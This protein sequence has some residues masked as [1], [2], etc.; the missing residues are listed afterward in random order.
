MGIKP[1]R[2]L[3]F[4][5][6]LMGGTI[7]AGLAV[8]FAPLGLPHSVVK[9]GGSMLW[10]LMIYWVVS[11]LLRRW[12]VILAAIIAGAAATV[13][14]F[15]KLYQAPALNAF[16]L[17]VPG[18]LLLGRVFSAWDILAYWVAIGIGASIDLCMRQAIAVEPR[19]NT[20]LS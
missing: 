7:L 15:F 9:Y 20:R 18:I 19:R 11:T 2:S 17:T 13:V 4:S 1:S 10:A 12:Q 6:A 5:S 16:R 14:E 3:A 8:R